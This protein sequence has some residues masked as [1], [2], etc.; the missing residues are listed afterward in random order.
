MRIDVLCRRQLDLE[1]S[2]GSRKRQISGRFLNILGVHFCAQFLNRFWIG[3]GMDSLSEVQMFHNAETLYKLI[4]PQ[5]FS[6]L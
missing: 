3:F 2:G 6:V 1:G 5:F 4:S